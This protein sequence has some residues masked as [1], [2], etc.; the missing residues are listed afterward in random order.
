ME[1]S[2]SQDTSDPVVTAEVK[3]C[4]IAVEDSVSYTSLLSKES[5][6]VATDEETHS[7]VFTRD[8]V[9]QTATEESNP[10]A[11]DNDCACSRVSAVSFIYCYLVLSPVPW[12]YGCKQPES[13]RANLRT[14]PEDKGCLLAISKATGDNC[15]ITHLIGPRCSIT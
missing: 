7:D 6:L 14:K 9:S 3:N 2:V 1:D 8:S 5:G 4:D 13:L 11:A 15:Y 10:V 12:I